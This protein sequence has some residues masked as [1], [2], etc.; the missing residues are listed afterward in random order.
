MSIRVRA[1]ILGAALAIILA[2]IYRAVTVGI[3]P[4]TWI[5]GGLALCLA[6]IALPTKQ[7]RA[8]DAAR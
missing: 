6:L 1:L 3:F 5:M 7:E 4:G 2:V 8:Q